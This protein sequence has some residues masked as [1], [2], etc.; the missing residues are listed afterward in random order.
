MDARKA[1]SFVETTWEES[2]LPQLTEYVSIPA[3]SPDFDPDWKAHGHLD[4]VVALAADWCRAQPLEGLIVEVIELEG[5]TQLLYLEVPGQSD[6]TVV[7]YGHLDKQPEMTG[8]HEG[9]G[10]WQPVLKEGKLYGR[11]GA[12]DGY[13]VFA[14]LTAIAAL[15]HAGGRHARCV[16]LIEASEESGSPDLP[17]HVEN[18]K[19]RIGDPD[20]VICLDSGCGNYEQLWCTTSLRGMAAGTLSVDVLTEG[21]H[22]GDAGGIVPSSF[23]V[24]RRLLERLEDASTGRLL[25]ESLHAA[26]PDER[27]AQAE[28]AAGILGDGLWRRF[29]WVDDAGPQDRDLAELILNRTWRPALA[30]TGA[31][32]LPALQDAGNV[33]RTRSSLKLSVRLPPTSDG[34]QA[35]ADLKRLL[36]ADPPCRTRVRFEAELPATGWN[37]PE[38]SPWLESAVEQASQRFFGKPAAFMGEGGTI[39]FMSML[40][41]QFPKA[42]F[43]VTGVL[44]PGSNAHGPNEFLHVETAKRLTCCVAGLLEDHLAARG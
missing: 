3:K 27:V 42:Q 9:L 40:G 26:I 44:G 31:G 25:L 14:S 2:I 4:R 18:L 20:L 35:A 38:L 33:L 34:A 39:P 10:P 43:V 41:E 21:V 36:E 37:A 13:A 19:D 24:L 6:A 16:A 29:P 30:V 1:E 11:G 15:Q 32:G 12:D 28:Q 23:R 17:A 22:S 8:W 7:L 5:R